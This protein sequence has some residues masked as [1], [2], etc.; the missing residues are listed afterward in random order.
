MHTPF[1]RRCGSTG[2]L[3]VLWLLLCFG[4]LPTSALAAGAA[5]KPFTI[6]AAAAEVTLETFS[7][8]AGA[9]V[10]Y[11]I[12]DVR[13]VTTQPV[14]GS[15]AVRE[16]LDRLVAGTGLV[17]V[18]DEKT[19][20]FVVRRDRNGR[21]P[22]D[23][24]ESQ[25]NAS[26]P[27]M[28]TS[29]RAR[30]S[31]AFAAFTA[32]ALSAQTVVPGSAA[33]DSGKDDTV[34]M[35]PFQ[36]S[37]SRDVGF[38][39]TSSLAGGRMSTDLKDTPLA[40]SVITKEFIQA[41]NLID[42]EQAMEWAVNSS[43]VRDDGQDR[44]FNGDGGSRT[45]VRGVVTKSLRN[46]FE[47]GRYTDTYSQERIDFA[48]GT[49]ALLIGNAGLGGASIALTKQGIFGKA[50]S[51]AGL[52]FDNYGAKRLTLDLNQPVGEKMA[53]RT[54]L[55]WQDSDSW[56]DRVF[57]R[58]KGLYLTASYR[59]W[60]KTQFRADFETYRQEE[61]LALS[62]LNDQVSGWDGNTVFSAATPTFATANAAGVTR[63]GNAANE[64][65][66]IVPGVSGFTTVVNYLNQWRTLGGAATTT[67]PVNGVI[68]VNFNQL[69][70]GGS[71]MI[72]I[73]NEPANRYTIATSKSKFF[74]PD[75]TTVTMPSN[76]PSFVQLL[77]NF[78]AFADQQVGEHLFLQ[79]AF[80][81]TYSG[82]T[83][84]SLAIDLANVYIDINRNQPNG[85]PNPFF[86]EPYSE[87]TRVNL[88]DGYDWFNETRVAAA[89]VRDN[90]RFGSFRFNVIAGRT[91]RDTDVRIYAP[92]MARNPD[93][94]QR[95]TF[96]GFGYRYYLRDSMQTYSPPTQ[97]A[98]YN[99][100]TNT[101]TTYPV[102]NYLALYASDSDNRTAKRTFENVQTSIFA[103]L[104][105]ERLTVLAGARR[106]HFKNQTW[107]QRTNAITSYPANWDGK[108]FFTNPPAPANYFDLTAAQKAFY[109]PPDIDQ[110]VNTV[111]YGSV[112]HL[113]SWLSGF[114][115][116]AQTY[117]T[118]RAVQELNGNLVSPLVSEGWDAGLR[119]SLLSGRINASLSTYGTTQNHT[120]I[121]GQG[122]LRQLT[123]A[124][125]V[126]DLSTT[127]RNNRG[128][129][130]IPIEWFDYQDSKAR[131]YEYEVVANLTSNWRLTYNLAFPETKASNRYSDTWAY[132]AKNEATLKLI[133]QDAGVVF[134]A[135][136]VAS[137]TIPTSQSPDVTTA[138]AAWN[139]MQV[140]KRSNDPTLQ[141]VNSNY[142]YTTNLYT[143]YRFTKGKLKGLRVGGG[144]QYRSKIQIGNRANDTIVNPANPLTAIDDPSV[145]GNSPVYMKP[146]YLGTATFAYEMRLP[147]IGRL[148]LNL[149]VS[150]LLDRD[151]PIYYSASVRPRNG[152]IL[153]PSRVTAGGPF[154]YP[155]PRKF[156]FSA[157]LSF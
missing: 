106:D 51:E 31:A 43:V 7:D 60:K 122:F 70:A 103:K 144:V 90:T 10:I 118:S 50:S 56:R 45:R 59:P 152:D 44:I 136:N 82:R 47:L 77:R 104:F 129:T 127:G 116:F 68:P 66:L 81:H 92:S 115:N 111:T 97:V 33:G 140:W 15:F 142:K 29:L 119:F 3:P 141:I 57:D 18:Q 153:N 4:C 93:M 65:N 23:A 134:D 89:Y 88:R 24:A 11:L 46:F 125:V 32:A 63:L 61:L 2:L 19:G 85:Q 105:K 37:T 83:T 109:N 117:D 132:L 64:F 87:N 8:Q 5:P 112:V 148:S 110:Y 54:S 12:E 99:A 36:V 138:V 30:L 80:S 120:I 131:G 155:E 100:P 139:A 126:G 95:P 9:Q 123:E 154:Y 128:L 58:R 145:D 76:L 28:K 48:R 69:G 21:P 94:R 6:P 1:R 107:N 27:A 26:T 133:A 39:A 16:A 86:L 74:V 121:G 150:N 101:T 62:H 84:N 49:N 71:Y 124:N 91:T 146:W 38:V 75:R 113:R 157:R 25:T 102:E 40:Y 98:Y 114:Y 34:T 137:T 52:S 35:S 108:S 14:H 147:N 151:A 22:A 13:G 17:V 149:N 72:D 20:A 135:N 67:T 55:L 96:D 53:V 42:T 143:D 41:L 130:I 156:S 78:S 79:A 73:P